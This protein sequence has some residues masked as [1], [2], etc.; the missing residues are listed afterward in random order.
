MGEKRLTGPICPSLFFNPFTPRPAKTGP[1]IVLLC[2]TLGG[3]AFGGER[4]TNRD[5]HFDAYSIKKYM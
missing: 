1:F 4:V 2:L 5:Y 3:K